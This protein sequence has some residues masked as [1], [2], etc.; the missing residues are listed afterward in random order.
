VAT[1]LDPYKPI[2]EARLATYR[3]LSPVRHF[4]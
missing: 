2:I 4:F 1:K 3:E